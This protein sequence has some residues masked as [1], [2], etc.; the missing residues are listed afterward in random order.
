MP[1]QWTA[2]MDKRLL[3]LALE[4]V[5][6]DNKAIADLWAKKYGKCSSNPS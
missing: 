3:L 1:V 4:L 6:I 5:K 2:E